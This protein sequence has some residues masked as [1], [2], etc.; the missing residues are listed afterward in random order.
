MKFF[1][2]IT[3]SRVYGIFH[4]L[5]YHSNLAVD[6]AKLCTAY[7]NPNYINSF[8]EV[9]KIKLQNITN[10][11]VLPQG[12]PT[13][14]ALSNIVARRL[15]KRLWGY[16]KN[17][18]LQYSRYADDITFS[19]KGEKTIKISILSKIIQEEGFEINKSKIRYYEKSSNKHIVTGLIVSDKIKI[20]KNFKKEIER[21]LY[22]CLKYGV[23][24]HLKFLEKKTGNRKGFFKEWIRGKICFIKMV[25]PEEG[26]KLF[27]KYNLINWVL[28]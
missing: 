12:A 26:E 2:T 22:F 21:H 27:A 14:P 15:D 18:N 8:D 10:K 7:L 23:E 5:G 17:N 28:G 20:P 1:D 16:A 25:E 6:L 11:A 19:G 3:E 13:S 9:T 4:S 24:D